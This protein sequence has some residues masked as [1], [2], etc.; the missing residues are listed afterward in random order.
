MDREAMR[1]K[2]EEAGIA[3]TK[4]AMDKGC[5]IEFGWLLFAK[6]VYPQG[7]NKDQHD[8][9]RDAF[10]AGATHLFGSLM[11]GLDEGDDATSADEKRLDLIAA[12]ILLFREHLKMRYHLT[13]DIILP[14]HKNP[15]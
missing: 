13:D 9:L 2:L 1:R 10:F 5:I 12:E 8:Q 3:I 4:E 7:I 11:E 14:E 15:N 6:L